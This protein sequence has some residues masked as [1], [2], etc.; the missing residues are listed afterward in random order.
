M[1]ARKEKKAKKLD[2]EGKVERDYQ[3]YVYLFF[4][5][6]VWCKIGS[7]GSSVSDFSGH[8]LKSYNEKKSA[9]N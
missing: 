1:T 2:K 4:Y 6:Y 5:C 9:A 3:R 7:L 8:R